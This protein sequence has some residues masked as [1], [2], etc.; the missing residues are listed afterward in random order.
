MK[1]NNVGIKYGFGGEVF[2][3]RRLA[4]FGEYYKIDMP[5]KVVKTTDTATDYNITVTEQ[6]RLKSNIDVIRMGLT[7]YFY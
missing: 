2:L 1:W 7:Y 3:S 4:L 5:N 6:F